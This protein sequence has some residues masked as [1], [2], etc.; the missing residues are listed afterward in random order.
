MGD[1]LSL[2]QEHL[3]SEILPNFAY[4]VIGG[5]LFRAFRLGNLVAQVG[6]VR[7]AEPPQ[8]FGVLL[9]HRSQRVL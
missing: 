3:S 9:A 8:F 4:E 6:L 5:D 1:E 2:K 7:L